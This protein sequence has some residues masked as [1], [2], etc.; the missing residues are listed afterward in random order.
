MASEEHN[1]VFQFFVNKISG[2]VDMSLKQK[3]IRSNSQLH[4]VKIAYFG[5]FRL[6][7]FEKIQ[8]RNS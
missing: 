1:D 5:K 6:L 8:S 4:L 7:D 3:L 2:R